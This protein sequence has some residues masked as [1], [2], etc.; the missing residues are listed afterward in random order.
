MC[1]DA[2]A[3]C[4]DV[5]GRPGED[6]EHYRPKNLYWFLAYAPANYLSSCR[7]C[8]SSRKINRFPLDEGQAR[9]AGRARG[10]GRTAPAAGPGRRRRG[11]GAAN[12]TPDGA[13][14][15]V[16]EPSASAKLRSRA[17]HTIEFFRL[18]RDTELRRS[19]IEAIQGYLELALSADATMVTNARKLASRFMPHGA[20]VRSVARQQNPA[21]V[22]T[23]EEEMQWH[24]VNLAATLAMADTDPAGEA[25]V[26]KSRT[27]TLAAIRADPPTGLT[28]S[29]V[30][31]WY[32]AMTIAP[33]NLAE[34][35]AAT[36]TELRT[37]G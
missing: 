32:K 20:A 5:V 15:W 9:R 1:G 16:V 23:V 2:C 14:D 4:L 21:L 7:R 22:P 31:A 12:R 37:T 33:G 10:T 8:N 11:A 27:Y 24:I 3:Y 29:T 30:A 25:D 26:I 18:N 34:H 13:Y 6:V 17:Q 28:K 35:V 19:R 36:V